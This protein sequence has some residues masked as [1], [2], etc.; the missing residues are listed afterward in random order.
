MPKET[1]AQREARFANQ[2][3]YV[4]QTAYKRGQLD[5]QEFLA[6]QTQP[7]KLAQIKAATDLMEQAGKIM[8]RAGYMI[9][10]INNQPGF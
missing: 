8:S 2:L 10:K 3:A 1:K 9:G 4:E 7:A 6:T 5:A